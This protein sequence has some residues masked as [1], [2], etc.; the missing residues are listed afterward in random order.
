MHN[1]IVI[2]SEQ[3]QYTDKIHITYQLY[4]RN[5]IIDSY[6]QNIY[7]I[8]IEKYFKDICTYERVNSI[9]TSLEQAIL[10]FNILVSNSI[11]P[12]SLLEIMDDFMHSTY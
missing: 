6:Q 2:L 3:I 1:N 11:M 10:I 8:G 9:T 12:E 4:A 5:Q 7:D